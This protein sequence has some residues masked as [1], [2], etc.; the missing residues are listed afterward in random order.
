MCA[1]RAGVGELGRVF[2][3]WT[4]GDRSPLCRDLGKKII[5]KGPGAWE[6]AWSKINKGKEKDWLGGPGSSLPET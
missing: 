4:G 5:C 1:K 3:G 2:F 6:L